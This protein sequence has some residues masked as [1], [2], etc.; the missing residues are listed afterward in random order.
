MLSLRVF[1]C[2]YPDPE[3]TT[4]PGSNSLL[5]EPSVLEELDADGVVVSNV[6]FG[7]TSFTLVSSQDSSGNPIVTISTTN[8]VQVSLPNCYFQINNS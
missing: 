2:P 3:G 4:T 8:P 5:L 6:T 1:L 7:P